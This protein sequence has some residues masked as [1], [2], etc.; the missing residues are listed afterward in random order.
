M[1][2]TVASTPAIPEPSTA[3]AMTHLPGASPSVSATGAVACATLVILQ[4]DWAVGSHRQQ[5]VVPRR[6]NAS[7]GGGVGNPL[8][9]RIA[10]AVLASHVWCVLLREP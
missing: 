5:V 2:T 8:L 10:M 7:V 9:V 3:A 1:L 4:Q 6:A